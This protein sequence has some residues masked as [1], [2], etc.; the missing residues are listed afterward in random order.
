MGP[1]ET[2]IYTAILIAASVLGIIV[3]YFI[4]SIV[5]NQRR[6]LR[7]QRDKL[8]VEIATLEN[9]RKRIVSDLHDE[10]GPLLSVVKFQIDGLDTRSEEEQRLIRKASENLDSILARIRSICNQL[11]PQVLVR[12]GLVRAI[13]DYL[14]ELEATAPLRIKYEIDSEIR[15]PNGSEI[16]LYRMVQEIVHNTLKHAGAENMF[17]SLRQIP[18]M[19]VL[20]TADDGRGFS[21]EQVA[22]GG[23]GLGLRN[24]SSRVDMLG[25][26]IY[27]TSAPGKGTSF[28]IE[29]PTG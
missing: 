14:D 17:I 20:T 18:H 26:D 23:S 9:E 4:I 29:I 19:L 2:K 12:K 24:I 6:L 11:M 28:T 10:L 7:I 13:Q 16:H 3:A 15:L 1:Q 8:K 22:R 5:R 21:V 27:I 25:G